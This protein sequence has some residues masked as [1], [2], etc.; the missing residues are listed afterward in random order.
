MEAE[1]FVVID[2][3]C[4]SYSFRHLR[5]SSWGGC[6]RSRPRSVPSGTREGKAA[7]AR[8][9]SRSPGSRELLHAGTLPSLWPSLMHE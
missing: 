2:I 1:A 5:A 7:S 4:P 8:R 3:V 6:P 9:A